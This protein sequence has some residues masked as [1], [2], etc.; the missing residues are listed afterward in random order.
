MIPL[1]PF[2]SKNFATSISP[3]IVTMEALEAFKT[4]NMQ[5]DP[6]PLPYLQ[7]NDN[8]NFDIT[9]ESYLKSKE[10]LHITLQNYEFKKIIN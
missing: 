8:Y 1:G 10:K 2:L 6:K 9:L 4:D 5:Q 3:W 7:H